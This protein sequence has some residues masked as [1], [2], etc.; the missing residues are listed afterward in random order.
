MLLQNIGNKID[1]MDFKHLH[2]LYQEKRK[3]TIRRYE[4]L[5]FLKSAS[6]NERH[7]FYNDLPHL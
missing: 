1:S 5:Q 7:K 2:Q 4:D 3:I 6:L